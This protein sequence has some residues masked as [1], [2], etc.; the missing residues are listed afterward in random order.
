MKLRPFQQAA[1]ETS[2]RKFE[3]GVTRQLIALPTGTGKTVV[4]A[5]IRQ[6]FG[7]KKKI[8]VLVHREELAQQAADKI[9]KW[10]PQARVG[11]E[12]AS[13]W[14]TPSDDFV[15]A[16]VQ[17]LGRE[18]SP[19]LA[20]F[21]PDEFDCIV[22]D[23]AHHSTA[24]SY[25]TIFEHFGL[26]KNPCPRLLL[27]VTATPNRGDGVPL[28]EVYD[29]IVYQMTMLDAIR[30]GWLV[31]VKGI[32]VNTD[33]NLDKV[34][35][36]AGDFAV[37]DLSREVN[38]ASRND[39]IVR[40]W[41]KNGQ[42]RQ[43]IVFTVDIAHA[44]ALAET[45]KRY[46]VAAEAVWGD[47]PYRA[48]K[49]RFH[50]AG[51]LRVLCNCQVL[52]EGYDDP[53]LGCI[54][55]ARPTKSNLLF[56]QMAGRGARIPSDIDNL[57]DAISTG[58]LVTKKDCILMDVV[59]NTSRH[60]LV[61][62]TS[63]FGLGNRVNLNGKDITDAVDQFAKALEEHPG[64][65]LSK[66]EDFSK[67]DSFVQE[68]NLFEV[69]YPADITNNS[70]LQ[71]HQGPDG[72]SFALM[73]PNHEN[74]VL[75]ENILGKWRVQ[76]T[77]NGNKM[78]DIA[79]SLPEA[80]RLADGFVTMFGRDIVHLLKREANWMTGQATDKQLRLLRKLRI[81]VPMGGISKGEAARKLNQFFTRKAMVT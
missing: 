5:C 58:K 15:V 75:T 26:L 16:S 55:M 21:L 73:L 17:T 80:F 14:A 7:F 31:N 42:D 1:L 12:M 45:F 68:V 54:V 23:E 3:A 4:F 61:T 64:V 48:D 50:K 65:D 29:E 62:L 52:T 59:D 47:D 63:I 44:G 76:G 49:L 66:L 38:N 10:N 22:C 34:K 51:T 2:K 69:K 20:R 72:K 32:R 13:S 46:G 53:K 71:W 19:R 81:P 18:G 9:R 67:L 79:S 28:G 60:S 24:P 70:L 77:V 37:G 43:T 6:V 30:A 36:Q 56:V 78:A 41:L 40:E 74:V 39:L 35:T 57:I 11:I 25:Q 27:G 8:M 33:N